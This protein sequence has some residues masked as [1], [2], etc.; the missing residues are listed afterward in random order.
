MIKS[1][2]KIARCCPLVILGFSNLLGLF[3]V[4]MANPEQGGKKPTGPGP[5]PSQPSQPPR[6]T[7]SVYRCGFSEAAG[8]K[9]TTPLLMKD[10]TQDTT[11][12]SVKTD[13]CDGVIFQNGVYV[14]LFLW[15]NLYFTLKDGLRYVC[16]SHWVLFLLKRE[17]R[18][19]NIHQIHFLRNI[20]R[21]PRICPV[22]RCFKSVE[23][24][25]TWNRWESRRRPRP[26]ELE[27]RRHGWA[28]KG[29]CWEI[30]IWQTGLLGCPRK[31]GING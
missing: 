24:K 9:Y 27:Q 6:H 20:L 21:Y 25:K 7:S 26:V 28:M 8:M 13:S 30:W 17:W 2:L 18:R 19:T 16:T 10:W 15:I 3:Q 1:T 12:V 5:W 11:F 31:L 23:T 29:R 22:S 4:I 14:H